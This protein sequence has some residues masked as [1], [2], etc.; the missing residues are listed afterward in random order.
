[1]RHGP[2]SEDYSKDPHLTDEG[3]FMVESLS[4]PST[5]KI[6][7]LI[8]SSKKRAFQTARIIQA[9][10]NKCKLVIDSDLREIAPATPKN[11]S[12]DTHPD[13]FRAQ[14]VFRNIILPNINN[15]KMF[16]VS[17]KNIL[18]LFLQLAKKNGITHMPD[19]DFDDFCSSVEIRGLPK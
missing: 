2:C 5:L 10:F 9:K 19:C 8:S 13:Y 11:S 7:I 15:S 1:M 4:F 16:I 3:R 14:K 17:H 6:D 12:F 18:S